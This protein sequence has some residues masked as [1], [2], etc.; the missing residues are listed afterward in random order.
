MIILRFP[1]H[2]QA[3]Q[4]GIAL[5]TLVELLKRI[6]HKFYPN[7]M[8]DAGRAWI[9]SPVSQIVEALSRFSY[10]E[11]DEET[12]AS[13]LRGTMPDMQSTAP[14]FVFG[15]NQSLASC[16]FLDSPPCHISSWTHTARKPRSQTT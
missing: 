15:D 6:A 5:M 9:C 3:L 14:A 4:S 12:L 16:C 1:R 7:S 8:A 2:M 10:D 13:A 11:Q